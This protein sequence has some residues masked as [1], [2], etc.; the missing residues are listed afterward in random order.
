[1]RGGGLVGGAWTLTGFY[2]A[3]HDGDGGEL[4]LWR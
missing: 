3:I 4:S 1:L 2:F